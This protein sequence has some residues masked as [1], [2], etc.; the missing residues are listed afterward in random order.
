[1]KK[2]ISRRMFIG[3][4]AAFAAAGCQTGKGFPAITAVRSP[5]GL[6]RHASIGTGNMAWGDIKSLRTHPKIEMAAFCDVDSKFLDRVKQEF[7]KARFYRDWRE[8][9]A[10]EGDAIDSLNISIPDAILGCSVEIPYIDSK[11]KIKVDPG[12]QPG[13]ILKLRGKGIP[14]VNGYSTGDYLIYV[15]VYVPKRVD[16]KEKEALESWKNSSSFTP[17]S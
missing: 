17:K 4:G 1:M 3:A 11:L 8:L 13:K 14:D 5:N 15:Q 7:P 12:T 9:L 2:V 16:R 6:L 10:K